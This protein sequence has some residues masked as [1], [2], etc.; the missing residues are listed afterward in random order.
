MSQPQ[1]SVIIPTRARPTL[2]SRAVQSALRQSLSQ[3]EVIVVIDG[4]DPETSSALAPIGDARVRVHVLQEHRG[5]SAARN[6]GV[7]VARADWVA[8]LDDDDEMLPE[9]LAMQLEAA[10]ASGVAYPIVVGR[11]VSRTS[12]GDSIL[13][14]ILPAAGEHISDY[15]FI[16]RGEFG[17]SILFTRKRLL[18][19]VPFP[20]LAKHQDWAWVLKAAAVP[21]AVLTMLPK[22]LVI[23]YI[24]ESYPSISRSKDWQYS[25][26]WAGEYRGLMSARSYSAFLLS[27]VARLARQK[28]AYT[29]MPTILREAIRAGRPRLRDLAIFA[30]LWL[31]PRGSYKLAW[32]LR[33]KRLG[34][35]KS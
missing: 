11:A 25:F 20:D 26:S 9:R 12:A 16:K 31:T 1:V 34:K 35:Q 15:L 2:V 17:S 19:V 29:A 30:A 27:T 24:D 28:K 3:L 21:G 13:R 4:E 23:F 6:A 5:A 7:A 8:F 33:S 14:Q 22:P 32:T 18:E 10:V